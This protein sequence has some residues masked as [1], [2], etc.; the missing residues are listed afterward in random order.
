MKTPENPKQEVIDDARR[1]AGGGA[2]LEMILMFLREKGFDKIDSINA[3]R[4]LNGTSMAETKEIIDHSET[5]SDRFR[6]D[7]QFRETA[8][9]ALRDIAASQD[10]S[11][12][13]IIIDERNDEEG[14]ES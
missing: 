5:W 14:S 11:L 9:K 7:M 12:P 3:I 4:A 8:W 2:S 1:L 13:K 10:P 6:R